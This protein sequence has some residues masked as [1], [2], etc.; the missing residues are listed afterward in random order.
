MSSSMTGETCWTLDL[1]KLMK[2]IQNLR[3]VLEVEFYGE[4]R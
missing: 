3:T 2:Y 4:V 1:M